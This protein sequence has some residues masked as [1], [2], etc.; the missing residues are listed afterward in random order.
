[1]DTTLA[2]SINKIE[3]QF[4]KPKILLAVIHAKSHDEGLHSAITAMESG[5]DGL[6]FVSEQ[7]LSPDETEALI[8]STWKHFKGLWLGVNYLGAIPRDAAA[9]LRAFTSCSGLWT[10]N[11][12]T[13]VDDPLDIEVNLGDGRIYFGGVA[14]KHQ[15]K[16]AIED[17]GLAAI[18]AV[19][20]GVDI[21]TTSGP[22][23]GKP[24]S[25]DKIKRMKFALGDSP[26]A[27]ASGITCENVANFLPW[28]DAFL[29]A[30]GIEKAFGVLDP[31]KVKR[32][33]DTIHNYQ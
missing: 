1:M 26:L 18:Q 33:A 29:V 28:T 27:I 2:S 8:A 12:M 31:E 7:D 16:V 15:P 3:R 9:R 22:E 5:A 21:V 19:K 14:F 20:Q 11:A 24:P 25:Q 4:N 23:T 13:V 10:D 30:T 17:A 32:L 6:F